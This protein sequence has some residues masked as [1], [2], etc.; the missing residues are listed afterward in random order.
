MSESETLKFHPLAEIFPLI[1]GAEFDDLVADIKA[2]GLRE[3]IVLF[4]GMIL[5]GRNRYRACLKAGVAPAPINGDKWIDDP[6]AYVVSANIHRRHLTQEH[7]R[8]LVAKLVKAQPEKSDRQIAKDA[9]VHHETVGAVRR[10]LEATGGIRQLKKTVGADG[11]SRKRRVVKPKPVT[12]A[13]TEK[14]VEAPTEPVDIVTYACALVAHMTPDM[15]R[16]FLEFLKALPPGDGDGLEG[17]GERGGLII[18]L[19]HDP[20]DIAQQL[21]FEMGPERANAVGVILTGE[22]MSTGAPKKR[23]LPEGRKNKPKP[24]V[25]P[26]TAVAV[27]ADQDP[28]AIPADLDRRTPAAS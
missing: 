17:L 8:K 6:A 22:A 3:D 18:N 25:E 4:E 2:N 16:D 10:D 11:K 24:V 21:L 5:D 26:I 13:K 7:K 15:R 27:D 12:E 1:E 19:A 28:W 23:G 9:K 14:K 20:A